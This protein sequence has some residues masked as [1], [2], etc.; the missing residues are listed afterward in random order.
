MTRE[1]PE[2]RPHATADNSA[3]PSVNSTVVRVQMDLIQPRNV[4]RRERG[5]MPEGHAREN[6]AQHPASAATTIASAICDRIS[7]PRAAPMARRTARS[8]CRPSA[9][10]MNRFAT[11]AHAISSTIADGAEQ[12][13]ER[14]GDGSEQL[15][16]E[17]AH[18][19][20]MLR[21]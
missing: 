12:D 9:R 13:P 2:S 1:S 18:D 4:R 20:A 15:F 16:L 7:C 8:R 11:F 14:T 17:R 3:T 19:G 10:T 21:R 6:D 5:E